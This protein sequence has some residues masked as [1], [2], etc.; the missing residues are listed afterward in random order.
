MMQLLDDCCVK[1]KI[2]AALLVGIVALLIFKLMLKKNNYKMD[3]KTKHLLQNKTTVE[4]KCKPV[5]EI[6]NSQP[7]SAIE[8]EVCNKMCN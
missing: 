7:F 1:S 2:K 6:L 3:S 8:K 4:E 5:V